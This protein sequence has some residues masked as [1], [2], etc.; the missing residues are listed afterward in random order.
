MRPEN[1][2]KIDSDLVVS[3]DYLL[4]G[5]S[6]RSKDSRGIIDGCI[7]PYALT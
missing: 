1:L 7:A 3:T 6:I 2:M 4:T 5:D